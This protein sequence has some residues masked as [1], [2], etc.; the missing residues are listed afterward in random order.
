MTLLIIGVALWSMTHLFP[1]LAPTARQ[2]LV[3]RLGE[4]AYKGGFALLIVAEYP[5]VRDAGLAVGVINFLSG[6]VGPVADQRQVDPAPAAAGFIGGG[7][8]CR[9][10]S[11]RAFFLVDR[12][13]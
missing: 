5:E 9:L 2:G 4:K 8:P 7:V 11:S 10:R 3:A 1:A 6:T 12:S 13:R